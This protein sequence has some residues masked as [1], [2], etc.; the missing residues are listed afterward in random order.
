MLQLPED[1]ED[2]FQLYY[3]VIYALNTLKNTNVSHVSSHV[4]SVQELYSSKYTEQ[5]QILKKTNIRLPWT[6]TVHTSPI[7]SVTGSLRH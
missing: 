4:Y 5:P 1:F 6:I 2:K 7:K 3:N